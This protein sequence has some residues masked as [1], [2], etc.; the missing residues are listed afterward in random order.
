VNAECLNFNKRPGFVGATVWTNQ[1]NE[2]VAQ[3]TL[4]FMA[5]K[6]SS[7][8]YTCSVPTVP[9]IPSVAFNVVVHRKSL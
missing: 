4:F 9:V 3:V 7:G 1:R 8:F 2:V 5:T 6:N